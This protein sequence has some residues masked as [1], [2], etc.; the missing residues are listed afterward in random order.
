MTART[1]DPAEEIRR[2]RNCINDLVGIF[3][4]PAMW[5]GA[6]STQIVHTLLGALLSMLGL[7]FVYAQWRDPGGAGP[8]E[9]AQVAESWEAPRQP[10][11][12]GQ[13]LFRQLGD[14]PQKWGPALRSPSGGGDI[15]VVP[16]RLGMH[17]D[18]GLIVAG[19][20]RLGFPEQAEKLVLNVAANQA[21]IGLQEARLLSEQKRLTSDL[22]QRVAQRT[23]ELA[24]IN[25]ELKREIA[26]RKAVEQKLLKE[27]VDL[28]RSEAH[29][30]AILN[31]SLD[32]IVAID[33]EGCITEFNPAAERTF[34][35]G[36]K[37]V[38]GKHLADVIIPPSLREQHRAGFARHLA[39]GETRVLGR[40]VEMTAL[41]A[42]GRE[43]PVEIAITRIPQD[44][45][46]SFTGFLRDISERK[47]NEEA[48]LETHAR[49]ARSE[50]RWRSV[51]ENSAIGVALTDLNGHFIATNPV[52][53]KM[54]GY[55]ED[56][57]G[58][59]RFLDITI[60]ED[61]D[62]TLALIQE[63]FEGKRRQFQLEKRYRRKTG[64]TVWV[65]NSVS[66]V[67]G[68][69]QLPGFLMALSEDITERRLAE[70][71]L[72][73]T[74]SELAH[75]T[76]VTTLSTLTA[77]I[78]HEV[79]QP[80]SGI[81]TNA[82]TC[83]RMLD[84]NPPNVE[85]ARETARR[86]IRDGNRA[87]EVIT[88]LRALFNKKSSVFEL[89]DL[90]EAA[91]EVL[92]LSVS[93]LQRDKV[94][95]QAELAAD[96]P[97]VLGDRIQIQQ[98]ILNL[99]RNGSDAMSAVNDRPKDLLVKTA[100]DKD[101]V[102]LSVK[103]SGVGIDPEIEQKLFGAFFTTKGDGMGVGL[104]VSRSIIENHQG[105]LWAIRNEGPGA[106]FLF[107]I[108]FSTNT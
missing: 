78:A 91:K 73:E 60:D 90:N 20:G 80:L 33:H 83:L 3:A 27:E 10:P 41:R 58:Q 31:S 74:R 38:V 53:Q 71:A 57:L 92:T 82:S 49:L 64:T 102:C 50:E 43:I 70:E 72:N 14:D 36:R 37:D 5:A 95:L 94:V 59:L 56:E 42:D 35:H 6:E 40:R 65:R 34:G 96:L 13:M 39:T 51:F 4:L 21:S 2:L 77:S 8:I 61:R 85:G 54:L 26:E 107:S 45:P 25:E 47:R 23:A 100:S 15:H 22:D 89:F 29:K 19:S 7:D 44:G 101:G 46:P 99:I 75:I 97:T 1:E 32:C 88:R 103:D 18:T 17:G 62:L 93:E 63:L 105:R 98:V 68:T 28:K 79:N 52:Y 87:S 30:A 67:P 16:L 48:L 55:T 76:R 108:P 84:A 81:V 106:T 9:I 24:A 104:S 12:I 66:V 69:E 86:T 11:D